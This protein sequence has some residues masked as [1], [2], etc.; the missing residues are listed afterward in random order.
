MVS[1]IQL[2][3][4]LSK[5]S[6]FTQG[7]GVNDKFVINYL[8]SYNLLKDTYAFN[9]SIILENLINSLFHLC[10]AYNMK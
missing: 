1:G 5:A 8:N 6:T 10:Q 4:L 3:P 2:K 7:R 9:L